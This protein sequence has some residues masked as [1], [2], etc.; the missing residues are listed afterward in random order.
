MDGIRDRDGMDKR[1]LEMKKNTKERNINKRTAVWLQK[2]RGDRGR[3]ASE[4]GQTR[5]TC[6]IYSYYFLF[7]YFLPKKKKEFIEPI[8]RDNS[9]TNWL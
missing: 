1:A 6:K 2:T 4:L 9:G 7:I 3:G 5:R 8:N